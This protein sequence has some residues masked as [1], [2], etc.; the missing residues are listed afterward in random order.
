MVHSSP[1]MRLPTYVYRSRHGIYFFRIVVPLALRNALSGQREIKR[2]LRTRDKRQALVQAR[3]LALDLY[4][5][6]AK[7]VAM[8]K[9]NNPPNVQDVLAAAP[10]GRK[11]TITGPQVMPDGSTIPYTV[12]TDSDSPHELEAAK[13]AAVKLHALHHT[14]TQIRPKEPTDEEWAR[15][16]QEQQLLRDILLPDGET[17]TGTPSA[18]AENPPPAAQGA[19]APAASSSKDVFYNDPDH[20]IGALWPQ[21]ASQQQGSEWRAPRTFKANNRMFN[22]FLAWAE[23]R[24]VRT[25]NKVL[26]SQFKDYLRTKAKVQAG[27]RKGQIGLDSRTVDNHTLVL[28]KFMGWAQDSGYY[29]E[30]HVLPT[31]K[32]VIVSKKARRQR[33]M[34]SNPAYTIEQL[35][36]VFDPKVFHPKLAHHFWPPLIALFTG[37]RRRE[38]AQLLLSDFFVTEGIHAMSINMDGDETQ[39]LKTE[40][41]KRTIPVHPVLIELGLLDYLNDVKA[42]GLSNEVFPGISANANGEKGNAVGHSWARQ[43]EAVGIKQTSLHTYHSFRSTAITVLKKAKVPIDM[44]SQ[45]V[46]HEF[47]HVGEGYSDKYTVKELFEEAIPKLIYEGLDLSALRYTSGQFDKTNKST[48]RLRLHEEKQRA[49]KEQELNASKS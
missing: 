1:D 16:E 24:D 15:F 31:A 44:R 6:F 39:S 47:D 2:S 23:D 27:K 43:L 35:K 36:T 38:I 13:A 22:T 30:G 40:A 25:I 49:L 29:H 17:A 7:A 10:N 33:A 12:K 5:V 48:H 3:A 14:L 8:S 19:Q 46:G 34:K 9:F 21:F 41:A 18:V 45:L 26:I 20:F 32:Q 11:L 42:L 28:N 37:G 4:P